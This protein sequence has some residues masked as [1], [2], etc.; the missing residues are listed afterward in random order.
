[1]SKFQVYG[2]YY[3]DIDKYPRKKE[4]ERINDIIL[5]TFFMNQDY[6]KKISKC[7]DDAIRNHNECKEYF[8]LF[9]FKIGEMNLKKNYSAREII[10]IM[11][12]IN[13]LIST[14]GNINL[15]SDML[16]KMNR[17]DVILY[18][19]L[20]NREIYM[21]VFECLEK[22]KISYFQG[23]EY[24]VKLYVPQDFYDFNQNINYSALELIEI[25]T[26]SQQLVK[27]KI[28]KNLP[29]PKYLIN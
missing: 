6:L 24:N 7:Y 10:Q 23:K 21:N 1:M 20:K 11:K 22:A 3:I 18:F 19:Y 12:N 28:I 29:M 15:V 9:Q 26:Y 27:K 25:Y 4:S 17:L 14:N 13:F 16:K 2:D 8:F 5:I